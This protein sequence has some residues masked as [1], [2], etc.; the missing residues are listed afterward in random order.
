MTRLPLA[1][2]L[3][4]PLLFSFAARPASAQSLQDLAGFSALIVSPVGALPPVASDNGSALP[5]RA[6]LAVDY[7]R[8]RFDIDDAIHDNVGITASHRL[9]S[10]P[11]TVSATGAMLSLSCD[12][13]G[14]VAGGVSISSTLWS[15]ALRGVREERRTLHVGVRL[16]AGG[17]EYLGAGHASGASAAGEL[18]VGGSTSFIAGSRLALSL[19]PGFGSGH[20][21][22]ADVTATGTRPLFGVAASWRF[23]HGVAIDLGT[24]RVVLKGGPTQLGIGMSWH[25][26]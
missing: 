4:L 8:W 7:G 18:D 3:V 14:W 21:N 20:L 25:A 16:S 9:G 22:S 1:L 23:R 5:D 11:A 26:R 6:T 10:F 15:S 12:C 13:A 17:A 24:E 2:P 19:V